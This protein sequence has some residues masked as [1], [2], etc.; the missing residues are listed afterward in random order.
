MKI[1]AAVLILILLSACANSKI[2]GNIPQNDSLYSI[3][4]IDSVNN[5]YMIYAKRGD[6]VYK[7]VVKKENYQ[8]Y[9][10]QQTIKIGRSYK[11]E[12]HSRKNAVLEINGIK[13]NPVNPLD[14]QCYTYDENTN[15]CIEPKKG[16][17]DLYH[18]NN[19]RGLCFIE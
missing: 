12:L 14:V 10:C 13:I 5:W 3:K 1:I 17:Y 2:S 8:N 9:D 18:T 7:I 19:I 15:I 11:L 4:A 6:S 16:I